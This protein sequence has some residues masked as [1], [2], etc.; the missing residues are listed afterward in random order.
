MIDDYVRDNHNNGKNVKA[1]SSLL[2]KVKKR[3]GLLLR[4]NSLPSNQLQKKRML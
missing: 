2:L 3:E 4:R 1:S